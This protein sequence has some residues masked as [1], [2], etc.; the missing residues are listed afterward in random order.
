MKVRYRRNGDRFKPFGMK[1]TKKVKDFL[2]DA[3]IDRKDRDKLPIITSASDIIWIVPLRISEDYKVS[4][5]SKNIVRIEV[6][7]VKKL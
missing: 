2:I 7:Y 3:K 4:S 6:G 1:N 5:K